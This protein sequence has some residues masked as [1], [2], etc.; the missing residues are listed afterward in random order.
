[1]SL[2]GWQPFKTSEEALENQTSIA[3]GQATDFLKAFLDQSL[4]SKKKHCQLGI[5]DGDLAKDL[6]KA[7]S[8]LNVIH[9]KDVFEITRCLRMHVEKMIPGLKETGLH[10]YQLGLAHCYSRTKIASDPARQDKHAQQAVAL[11]ELVDKTMNKFAM[12]LREWYGWHFP[13]LLKIVADHKQFAECALCIRIRDQFDFGANRDK[14]LE[15][16]DNNEELVEQIGAA[17]NTTMGQ[18]IHDLDMVN[19]ETSA[20]Q[21]I[22]IAEQRNNL[23]DY[24]GDK[25]TLVAPNLKALVG[26]ILGGKLITQAGSVTNLAKAPSSTIQILGAEKALF[27]ALKS[28]GPTPKYGLL[29]TSGFIGKA[30]PQNKGEVYITQRIDRPAHRPA[31][32]ISRSNSL[33][34]FRTGLQIF[35]QQDCSGSSFGCFQREERFGYLWRLRHEV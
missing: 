17:L 5:S 30:T 35:G 7:F 4:P 9:G 18:E 32:K 2:R 20:K 15:I 23:N 13:E 26:E 8:K 34:P 29:F 19:I 10:Q 1:M 21:V 22:A 31:Y 6:A 3:K 25:M 11:I 33:F 27:R 28:R 14:L 24:L 12:R 16:L